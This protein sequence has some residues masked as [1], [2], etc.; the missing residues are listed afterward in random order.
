MSE[1]IP[2]SSSMASPSRSF[3]TA[4]PCHPSW[5]ARNET[6]WPFSVRATMRVGPSAASA[7]VYASSTAA[8][9]CPSI[10]MACQ[11]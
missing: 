2:P 7:S 11:P 8:T 6:P 9:S 10:S 1:R 5:S 4:F 3:G